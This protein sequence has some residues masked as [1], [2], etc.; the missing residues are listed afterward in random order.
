MKYLIFEINTVQ[1]RNKVHKS[2]PKKRH[3]IGKNKT[4]T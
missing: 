3:L 1:T 2:V 4:S